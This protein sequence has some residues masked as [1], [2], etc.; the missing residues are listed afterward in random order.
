MAFGSLKGG[1]GPA[2]VPIPPPPDN[3]AQQEQQDIHAIKQKYVDGGTNQR[4]E[5]RL[6]A[7][8]GSMIDM[9]GQ[10]INS[11]ILTV[12]TGVVYGYLNDQSPNFGKTA[13]LPDFCVSA[14]IVPASMQIMI[15]QRDDYHISFQEGANSTATA[16]ARLMKI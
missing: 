11:I 6:A 10:P 2:G 1:F 5:L 16:T 3:G 14:G 4:L 12:A 9:S 15:P 7:N 13:F 8:G